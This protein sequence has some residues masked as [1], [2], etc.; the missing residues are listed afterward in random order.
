MTDICIKSEKVQRE[1]LSAKKLRPPRKSK[2]RERR[3]CDTKK[4]NNLIKRESES[5][6]KK[7][8]LEKQDMG[9]RRKRVRV[10]KGR[11][12]RNGG[13]EKEKVNERGK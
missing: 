2:K 11:K 7:R 1:S 10:R 6:N 5:E 8:K 3:K 12:D 4:G 9:E 13:N